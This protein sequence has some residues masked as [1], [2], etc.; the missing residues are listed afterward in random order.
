MV[1]VQINPDLAKQ[2]ISEDPSASDPSKTSSIERPDS[3]VSIS[4]RTGNDPVGRSNNPSIQ[5]F[6][7]VLDALS[8]DEGSGGGSS[9]TSSRDFVYIPPNPRAYY[10]RLVE[11]A[12]DFD[13]V[14]G[15]RT[16]SVHLRHYTACPRLNRP[17]TE[18]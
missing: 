13:L 14:S 1:L 6:G 17:K 12:I 18:F 9:S 15:I 10:K 5:S 7:S 3:W 11:K 16:R 2:G 8:G 4:D